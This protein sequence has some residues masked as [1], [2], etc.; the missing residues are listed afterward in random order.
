[1]N[2]QQIVLNS[3]PEGMPSLTNFSLTDASLAPIKAGE[4]LVKNLWMSVDPYMRGRMI[5]RKSY[6]APFALG[7]VLEGGAIG[8]IIESNHA[9]FPVGAKVSSMNGW[10]SH[11]IT[12]GSDHTLLPETPLCPSHFLGVL[13]MPGMTAWTGLN[14]IAELK[15]GETLFVS[16]ASGAVGSV[17]CQLGLLM[18]AKVVASVGSDEKAETLKAMGVEQVIN[19]KTTDNLS[20]ALLAAAPQG[21]D[22]YFE[23]VGGEHLSAALDNMNDHGRI[24]VC[25]MISQYNDTIPTPGPSNLA[26]IIMKKLK[27]EGFIVFEHWAHYPEFAKQ[28]GQWLASGQVKAEQTIYEGLEQAPNAFIGLFEG[29]NSGKMVVK[30]A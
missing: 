3:R 9:D 8:E 5:D 11:Y 22:V 18:G 29:K 1:M 23:N 27:I 16:A 7:E 24:A 26:Y 19:Y 28:M 6:I 15:K 20:A 10:R 4:F 14:R 25:G 30:V 21:I 2:V 17:A 13:G 12:D